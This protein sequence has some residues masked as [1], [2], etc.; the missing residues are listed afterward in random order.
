MFNWISKAR[1][2]AQKSAEQARLRV[3]KV[4]KRP[5]PPPAPPRPPRRP[6]P[7]EPIPKP[8]ETGVTP[9]AAPSLDEL[10]NA[11][12]AT[13]V[14]SDAN[15]DRF[16]NSHGMDR[17]ADLV[18]DVGRGNAS[19]LLARQL[20][21]SQAYARGSVAPGRANWDEREQTL[22]SMF[23]GAH[24]PLDTYEPFFWYHA[25]RDV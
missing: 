9:P 24:A 22:Q 14:A 11:V 3:R 1:A 18:E 5:A 17:I 16:P 21:A 6:V 15:A 12:R 7:S 20:E 13:G 8:P 23:L 10:L 2:A 4:F 25:R 19:R